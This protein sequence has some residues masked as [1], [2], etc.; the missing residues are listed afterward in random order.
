MI[1]LLMT[2]LG[3]VAETFFVAI[4]NYLRLRA[5][6]QAVA[7]GSGTGFLLSD[8]YLY[9][10]LALAGVI[11]G[12]P[13]LAVRSTN[14]AIPVIATIPAYIALHVGFALG[15]ILFY[16][17]DH[18]GD[19][20]SSMFRHTD[21]K[22]LITV[23]AV[24]F[25]GGIGTLLGVTRSRS[26]GPAVPAVAAP[27]APAMGVP[28]APVMG[29]PG[30]PQWGAPQP[31]PPSGQPFSTQPPGQPGVPPAGQPFAAPGYAAP[32]YAAPGYAAPQQAPS[33]PYAQPMPGAVPPPLAAPQAPPAA[34]QAP[35]AAPQASPA[36]A[37][38]PFAP[39]GGRQA[40]PAPHTM[41]DANPAV[42]G[43]DKP[44]P[45]ADAPDVKAS[46]MTQ[47]DQ[48]LPDLSEGKKDD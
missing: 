1:A 33:G 36:Q 22:E 8:N 24:L 7:G 39:D 5:I 12:L 29:A 6:G 19:I 43:A 45:P 23:V 25:V 3:G 20:L 46:P 17:G 30:A 38:N 42:I 37:A 28:G 35:P 18:V 16:S 21:P 9:I 44:A 11:A 32:G 10:E 40:A 2:L 27:G 14:A 15:A 48:P 47:L 31:P 13:L 34:P 4:A 26:A 41:L